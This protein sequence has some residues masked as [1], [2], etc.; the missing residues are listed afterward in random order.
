MPLYL[1]KQ[2]GRTRNNDEVY[3]C[4]GNPHVS[5]IVPAF[6][7]AEYIGECL[8]SLAKQEY[9]NYSVL[10]VDDG[11]T[12]GTSSV[13]ER[14][15][16]VFGGALRLVQQENGG[17]G[18]ARN[19]GVEE[20]AGKYIAFVD[21]DDLVA[22]DY[23]STFVRAAEENASDLVIGGYQTFDTDT[24][25]KPEFRSALDWTVSFPSGLRHT[26]QY[27]P[28]AKLISRDLLEGTGL[29]YVPGEIMEDCPHSLALNLL[30]D[31]AVPIDYV[32]YFYR[33]RRGS[34]QAGVRES[35]LVTSETKSQFPYYGL[36]NACLLVEKIKDPNHFDVLGYCVAKALAGFV[37][38]FN[39]TASDSDLKFVCEKSKSIMDEFFSGLTLSQIRRANRNSLP[40]LHRAATFVFVLCWKWDCIFTAAKIVRFF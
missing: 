9:D 24:G 3:L 36:R 37:F 32:G 38:L 31:N 18:S 33:R 39:K 12:D 27:S 8:D 15:Y 2:E 34:V 28:C 5:V 10:V 6:N 26:F 1:T 17:A 25:L 30:A 40:F 4:M 23:L 19:R 16:S 20:S 22:P 13:V 29:K 21:S 7:C 14:H 35:G 11:S